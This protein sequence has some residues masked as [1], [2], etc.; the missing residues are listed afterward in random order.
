MA[1]KIVTDSTADL[2]RD[3]A[4]Q[5]D[6]RV[7]PL[8][9]R[10]GTETYLDGVQLSA[11]EFFRKLVQSPVLPTTAAP[12][13]GVFSE[14]YNY[15]LDQG[16]EVLSMHISS[17]LSATFGSAVA[18]KNNLS[19]GSKV[20]VVDTM[21]VSMGLGLLA[22]QAARVAVEGATLAEAV[23][24]VKRK[25]PAVKLYGAFD[26]LEYLYKGGRIG[27]AQALLGSMLNLKPMIVVRDGEVHPLER[28]RTR[29]KAVAR[30]RQLVE[31]SKDPEELAVIH[32]TTPDDMEDLSKQ[33]EKLVPGKRVHRTQFGPVLGTY[34]GPG[35]LAVG[36][37]ER[38]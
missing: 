3:L 37:L 38:L 7:V 20:E 35:I 13:P 15:L 32:A 28:V 30:L 25:M 12:G 26:T 18:G 29:A 9:V 14:L 19:A 10:F 23:E 27:R 6:I 4:R 36:L 2:P 21:S 16:H 1:L 33:V 11:D 31:N 8:T 22:L 24:L 17:K 34:T 5:L